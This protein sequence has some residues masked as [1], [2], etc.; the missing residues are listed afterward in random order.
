MGG[1]LCREDVQ[2][3]TGHLDAGQTD[4]GGPGTGRLLGPRR[5]R[6]PRFRSDPPCPLPLYRQRRGAD[7]GSTGLCYEYVR[8]AIVWCLRRSGRGDH[9]FVLDY[10]AKLA[11]AR[12][13]G[14]INGSG[15]SVLPFFSSSA[16]L[17]GGQGRSRAAGPRASTWRAPPPSE[18]TLVRGLR[19]W[20][21]G[22]A[23][24]GEGQGPV[25]AAVQERGAVRGGGQGEPSQ[26][27]L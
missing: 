20:Y 16:L 2:V 26:P 24:K 15:F 19:M 9:P 3:R 12:P 22:G 7:A 1:G 21:G 4:R 14:F 11:A 25:A 10:E 8:R 18:R 6:L 5:R 27:K 13:A 23:W 17:G